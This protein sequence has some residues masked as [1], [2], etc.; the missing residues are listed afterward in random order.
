MRI[1]KL[2][3]YICN[4][5]EN[6]VQ[7]T[8]NNYRTMLSMSKQ[9]SLPK[10]SLILQEMKISPKKKYPA[11]AL[12]PSIIMLLALVTLGLSFFESTLSLLTTQSKFLLNTS[13]QKSS[14]TIMQGNLYQYNSSWVNSP[15]HFGCQGEPANSSV[16]IPHYRHSLRALTCILRG[17]NM[18]AWRCSIC[19]SLFT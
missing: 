13:T 4:F 3:F 17:P 9:V 19:N 5:L 10:I 14:N 6:K 1:G 2:S 11:C 8:K 16:Q 7:I 12:L 15:L 18:E